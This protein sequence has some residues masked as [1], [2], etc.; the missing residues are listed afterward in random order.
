LPPG[1]E[2]PGGNLL[3]SEI[4]PGA[5]MGLG[6][7]GGDTGGTPGEGDG[8]ACTAR[9]R[10]HST[11]SRVRP[12][13]SHRQAVL[14]YEHSQLCMQESCC[15]AELIGKSVVD[16]QANVRVHMTYSQAVRDCIPHPAATRWH[17]AAH[18]TAQAAGGR[19]GV[20][21]GR[22][23]HSAFSAAL[24]LVSS[25]VDIG[26]ATCSTLQHNMQDA[27]LKEQVIIGNAS[28]T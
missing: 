7:G 8:N 12:L 11:E 17:D 26:V 21:V 19:A 23:G 10:R 2:K 25:L 24:G 27:G 4:V 18:H 3:I 22:V 6:T 9:H 28:I 16:V 5:G 1:L 14:H 15:L 20:D 13:K